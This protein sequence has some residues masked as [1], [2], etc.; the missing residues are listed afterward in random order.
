M[1]RTPRKVGLAL[2]AALLASSSIP[3]GAFAE[4]AAPAAP[5]AA[6]AA[7]PAKDVPSGAG[8]A[9]MAE[10]ASPP[11]AQDGPLPFAIAHEAAQGLREVGM[12][13]M[14]IARGDAAT[15]AQMIEAAK[16]RFDGAEGMAIAR[17]ALG[18]PGAAP[19][20]DAAAGTGTAPETVADAAADAG[21][22]QAPDAS[23]GEGRWLPIAAR[24]SVSE[25]ME[26]SPAA[27]EALR[28]AGEQ[29]GSGDHQGA[30]ETLRLNGIDVVAQ[31]AMLPSESTMAAIGQ[32][33]SLVQSGDLQGADAQLAAIEAGLVIETASLHG[34]PAAEPGAAVQT[35]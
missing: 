4:T 25:T 35:N 33:A 26:R 11:A 10:A 8:D 17:G 16:T 29:I 24:M 2:A 30:R 15:A 28:A 14:L 21:A 5:P 13:R 31:V 18:A 1:R 6:A 34:A 32:A 7:G 22:L 27:A 20:A 12:A 19:G 23:A 9:A 3:F